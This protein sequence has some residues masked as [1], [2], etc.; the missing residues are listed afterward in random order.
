MCFLQ[1]L[2][3]AFV[4]TP[5]ASASLWHNC[6]ASDPLQ[7]NGTRNGSASC[8]PKITPFNSSHLLI[9]WRE[10]F[11]VCNS[12]HIVQVKIN[13]NGTEE[14]VTL[15]KSDTTLKADP[16][17]EHKMFAKVIFREERRAGFY[18]FWLRPVSYNKDP[19]NPYGGLL[20]KRVAEKICSRE[21][22]GTFD[23]PEAPDA[24]KNCG[25][26]YQYV[27]VM[28]KGKTTTNVT[29]S[30]NDPAN[31]GSRKVLQVKNIKECQSSI[32]TSTA[33]IPAVIASSVVVLT[34]MLCILVFCCRHCLKNQ[35]AKKVDLNPL[36]GL[37]YTRSGKKIEQ[38][39]SEIVHKNPRYKS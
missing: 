19:R 36:Y 31:L 7:C 34:V 30:F 5:I 10:V 2:I 3:L 39:A 9:S 18:K 6:G 1:L 33:Q 14:V 29:I 4:A 13:F 27:V 32:S 23:I 24:L 25:V 38:R 20:N 8:A 16:C 11:E 28:H 26:E 17:S 22:Y 35:R 21:Q 12:S 37:Y 15:N